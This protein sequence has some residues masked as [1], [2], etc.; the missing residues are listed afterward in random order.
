MVER[1]LYFNQEEKYVPV[2]CGKCP[3]CLKRRTASWSHRL[4]VESLNWDSLHFVTLTYNTDFVPISK[5]GFMTLETD[6]VTKFFK[7]L[8]HRCGSFKY[9]YCGEY[10]TRK[11]RPHYHLILMGTAALTPTEIIQEWTEKG[12]P[13]GDIY[14]GKVEP[15]SIRYTVQYYDKG[16]WY[17]AHSRDDRVPEFSRMSNGIGKDFIN[18]KM[19]KHLLD[20]P[21]KG[22][23]YNKQG[24]K[25]A[26]PRYYK[27][28]LYDANLPLAVVAEHPSILINRD[29]LQDCKVAH[30]NA[31]ADALKDLEPIEETYE[32]N[33][34]RRMAIKNYQNEKRKTRK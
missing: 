15:A 21:S 31:L 11:K 1:K 30:N 33:E 5:N 7:R 23:I 24:H 25:I 6:R 20:N 27:K 28:R 14:F 34:A 16:T 8:R 9:Y 29:E 10:G 17:P 26:I 13:I 3:E 18:P 32:L 19:A 2:P 22:F 4:E 12:K